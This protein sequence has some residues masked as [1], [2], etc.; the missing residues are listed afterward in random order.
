MRA[1]K[2]FC[3]PAVA[4]EGDTGP[5]VRSGK[6]PTLTVTESVPVPP[7]PVQV[8][9]KVFEATIAAVAVDPPEADT[10]PIP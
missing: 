3:T 4:V 5:A 1:V 6:F 8:R 2:V 9:V 10:E 7:G